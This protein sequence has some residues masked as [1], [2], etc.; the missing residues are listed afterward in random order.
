MGKI[1]ANKKLIIAATIGGRGEHVGG[2]HNREQ[3]IKDVFRNI[4]KIGDLFLETRLILIESNSHDNVINDVRE[5][6]SLLG[7]TKLTLYSLGNLNY[8]TRMEKISNSR[9]FYLN[10]IE[11]EFND[12]DYLYVIDF[13]ETNVEPYNIAGI[14]SN[15]EIEEDWNMV[16]ANQEQIYYDLYALRHDTWMP[17]NCWSMIGNRP[18]FI[19]EEIAKNIYLKSR[20]INLPK[21]LNPIKVT[22]AFGGSAFIKINKIKGARHSAY[23]ENSEIDCEWVPFCKQI[24]NVYINPSFINMKKLSRHCI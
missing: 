14:L 18:E 6:K 22:S 17:F 13:N 4:K 9:N 15:F 10:I 20:F 3:I 5:N 7:D 16:C 21:N 2:I 11:E 12:Y 23:D 19:S 8:N 1:T 24:G